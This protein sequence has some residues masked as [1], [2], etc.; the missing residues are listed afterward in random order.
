MVG[1]ETNINP[2]SGTVDT[3]VDLELSGEIEDTRILEL[4]LVAEDMT[5]IETD[6]GSASGIT[7]SETVGSLDVT[8]ETTESLIPAPADLVAEIDTTGQTVG[9]EV[10]T[11]IAADVE[12]M[13]AGEDVVSDPADGLGL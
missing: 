5:S 1:M 4:D 12:G 3:N 7:E 13:S 9:G 10:D 11:G 2:E 6:L 8:T